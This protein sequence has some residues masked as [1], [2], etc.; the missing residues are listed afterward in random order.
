MTME[1]IRYVA[2]ALAGIGFALSLWSVITTCKER[3]M[4]SVTDEAVLI[5][6]I[7]LLNEHGNC[8]LKGKQIDVLIKKDDDSVAIQFVKACNKGENHHERKHTR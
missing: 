4:Q 3:E 1:T 6:A 5:M 7:A 8:S 2:L